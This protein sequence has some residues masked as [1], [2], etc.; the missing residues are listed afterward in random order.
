MA[1]LIPAIF[2]CKTTRFRVGF[3]FAKYVSAN[4]GY[5]RSCPN[6][7]VACFCRIIVVYSATCWVPTVYSISCCL[8][9]SIVGSNVPIAISYS[10][11]CAR[12]I[13]NSCNRI[14]KRGMLNSVQYNRTN[15]NLSCIAFATCF[16]TDNSR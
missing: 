3:L 11:E 8:F 13:Y 9:R 16:S 14:W 1:G 7:L 15:C 4:C 2:Y 5:N 10:G 6:P 12:L